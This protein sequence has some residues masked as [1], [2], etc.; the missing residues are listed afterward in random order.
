VS[1]TI[2]G[3][4][5]GIGGLEYAFT[6]AG[7]DVSWMVEINPFCQQ[8]LRKHWPY[9]RIHGDVHTVG[10][11]DLTPV[12]VLC[13]GFPCQPFSI[14]GDARGEDDPR[15]LW[16]QL[17]RVIS[18]LR[19]RVVFLENVPNLRNVADGAAFNRIL[20]QL[21]Q[22]GYDAEWQCLRAADVGAPHIRKR[23]F[24]VAYTEQYRA[25]WAQS[26]RTSQNC[27]RDNSLEKPRQNHQPND[28]E[29]NSEIMEYAASA[30][31]EEPR[32]A[33]QWQSETENGT[34]LDTGIEQSN[35][36]VVNTSRTG[37]QEPNPARIACDAGHASGRYAAEQ[38]SGLHESSLGTNADGLSVRLA[39]H[40][41]PAGQGK[42]QYDYEPSRTV[43]QKQKYHK[44]MI[45]AVGNAVVPQVIYP[46]ALA[47]R[48]YLESQS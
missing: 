42:F 15:H 38:F 36:D 18:E 1:L 39:G 34:G 31:L 40:T 16:P 12:D 46:L 41:F 21:A 37:R 7:F 19:P 4:F 47:I 44:D 6:A 3:L 8:V 17:Y 45:E 13:G 29:R 26:G 9:A 20:G 43:S 5:S 22:S 48:E 11:H 24:I 30:R 32:R 14:A 10:N 27:E 35:S 33:G 2:G 28:A 25:E 23:I